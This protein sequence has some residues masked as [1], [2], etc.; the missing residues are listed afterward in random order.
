MIQGGGAQGLMQLFT[1]GNA[2]Y[3]SELIKQFA[4]FQR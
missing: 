3:S 4:A 2:M 1:Y